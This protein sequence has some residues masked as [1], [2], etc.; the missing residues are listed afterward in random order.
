MFDEKVYHFSS[1]IHR[2]RSNAYCE[3]HDYFLAQKIPTLLECRYCRALF[4]TDVGVGL[5]AR[6]QVITGYYPRGFF[7][8]FL[9]FGFQTVGMRSN[10]SL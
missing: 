3:V 2:S 10:Q 7:Q 9:P 4:A 8:L 1:Q 6:A 5:R